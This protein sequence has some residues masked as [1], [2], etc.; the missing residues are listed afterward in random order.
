MRRA[1]LSARSAQR[2]AWLVCIAVCA[3]ALAVSSASAK[4][5]P[6]VPGP[7]LPKHRLTPGAHF[8]VGK[9]KVCK[10]GY[11][12]SVRNAPESVKDK[13]YARYY[14]PWG[15]RTKDRLEKRLHALVCAGRPSLASARRQEAANWITAYKRY[16]GPRSANGAT[17]E[18]RSSGNRA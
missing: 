16:V 17:H 1:F 3:S 13:A 18:Q 2:G 5:A 14:E 11:P 4:N 15:A 6:H 10:P 7:A 8:A 12:A 9:A